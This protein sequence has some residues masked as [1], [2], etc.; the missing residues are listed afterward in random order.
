MKRQNKC[1]TL[2]AKKVRI[3]PTSNPIQNSF[4]E[5]IFLNFTGRQS[6]FIAT[7]LDLP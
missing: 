7:L 5:T 2:E 1:K 6:P 4:E 3:A